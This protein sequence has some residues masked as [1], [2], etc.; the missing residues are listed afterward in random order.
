[1]RREDDQFASQDLELVYI[2]K[3]LKDARK[4]EELLT[5]ECVDFL[6]ETDTYTGGVIFR[7][8]RVGAFFFV[9]PE[10]AAPARELLRRHSF[11]PYEKAGGVS[12]PSGPEEEESA[13]NPGEQGGSQD[14]GLRRRQ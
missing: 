8:H 10:T 13:D 7:S 14:A 4:L 12:L 3:R 9:P 5:A 11:K 6:I 1:M 2:A